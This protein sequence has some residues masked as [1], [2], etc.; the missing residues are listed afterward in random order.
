MVR[1]IHCMACNC[2]PEEGK[3]QS[4]NWGR[5]ALW[6]FCAGDPHVL[7]DARARRAGVT[8]EVLSALLATLVTSMGRLKD[9]RPSGQC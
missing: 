2:I 3:R 5:G 6:G 4:P 1:T 9:Y 7:T 8:P